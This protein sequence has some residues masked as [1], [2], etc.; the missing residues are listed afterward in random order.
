V[1]VNRVLQTLRRDR[2]I[3]LR[4]RRLRILAPGRLRELAEFEAKYL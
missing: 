4:A 3:S 1:H 2:L